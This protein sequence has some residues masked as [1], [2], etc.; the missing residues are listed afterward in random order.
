MSI[1]TNI[2][3]SVGSANILDLLATV[4]SNPTVYE[5]KLKALQEAVAENQK[6]VELV[7]PASDIIRMQTDIRA[8][9]EAQDKATA[10]AELDAEAE[11]KK[12]KATAESIVA[13]ANAK[14]DAIL[15]NAADAEAKA[16]RLLSEAGSQLS[17]ATQAKDAADA[18]TK[19]ANVRAEKLTIATQEQ[20]EAKAA[21]D[22]AKADIIA[23]HKAFIESL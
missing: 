7:G 10:Q 23:R 4:V 2:D 13:E 15:A 3:G 20:I 8:A 21:Y 19:A 14:A 11:I 5:A 9:K 6:Y 22:A 17:A 18:A 16:T 1:S 12:A